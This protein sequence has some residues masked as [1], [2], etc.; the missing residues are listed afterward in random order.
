MRENDNDNGDIF[1]WIR[2]ARRL[3]TE[4]P[5]KYQQLHER[6]TGAAAAALERNKVDPE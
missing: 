1:D 5:A 4:M 6:A 3:R 2:I